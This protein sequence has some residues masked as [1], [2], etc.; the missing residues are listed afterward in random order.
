[1]VSEQA[2][3]T[4]LTMPLQTELGNLDHV[5]STK[6]AAPTVRL[7][8]LVVPDEVLHVLQHEG[9]RLVVVEYVG[10]GEE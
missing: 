3:R 1:M 5:G 4:G 7:T 6:M 10:D 8:P 9:R 2:R